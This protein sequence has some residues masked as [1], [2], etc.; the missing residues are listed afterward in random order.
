[1][2]NKINIRIKKALAK[3]K[4][5]S[6]PCRLNIRLIKMTYFSSNISKSPRRSPILNPLRVAFDEYVGPIP[7][8]VVP[9]EFLPFSASWSPSTWNRDNNLNKTSG[10]W[11]SQME[12][13]LRIRPELLL[14][15]LSNYEGCDLYLESKTKKDSFV[16]TC[17]SCR[18][19][20]YACDRQSSAST[21]WHCTRILWRRGFVPVLLLS[22]S[23]CCS[24]TIPYPGHIMHS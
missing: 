13:A 7:F 16:G 24:S 19:H 15:S 12:Y 23:I 22:F 20:Q 5:L 18:R 2:P 6:W 14:V 10:I 4:Y 1:M 3:S 11:K 17:S 9:K 8:F 21:S